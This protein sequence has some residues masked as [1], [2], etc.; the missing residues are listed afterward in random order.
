[1]VSYTRSAATKA[2]AFEKSRAG[3]IALAVW[4]GFTLVSAGL[5]VF[6]F[7]PTALI[8]AGFSE[9]EAADAMTTSAMLAGLQAAVLGLLAFFAWKFRSRIAMAIGLAF[10]ALSL[11]GTAFAFAQSG[12]LSIGSVFWTTALGV[13]I[14]RG[15]YFASRWHKERRAVP[16]NASAVFQ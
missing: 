12:Q 14:A 6:V 4:R 7:G 3:G 16:K 13:A 5:F 9:S 11:A 10:A 2:E 15:L 1:M 8:D